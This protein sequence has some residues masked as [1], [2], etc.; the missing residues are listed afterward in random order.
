VI[1][2]FFIVPPFCAFALAVHLKPTRAIL[3]N[4]G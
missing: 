1:P 4:P 2:T 3:S